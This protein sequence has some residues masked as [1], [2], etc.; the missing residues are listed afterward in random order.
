MSAGILYAARFLQAIRRE[1]IRQQELLGN[2]DAQAVHAGDVAMHPISASVRR[3]GSFEVS[4]SLVC[5]VITL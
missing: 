4:A 5:C 1:K 3:A 2:P